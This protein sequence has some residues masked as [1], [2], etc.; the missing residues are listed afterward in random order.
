MVSKLQKGIGKKDTGSQQEEI[1]VED[2]D[3]I[4]DI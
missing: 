4:D 3:D 2:G 1:E